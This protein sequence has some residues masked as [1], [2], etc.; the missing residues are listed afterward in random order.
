VKE[1]NRLLHPTAKHQAMAK[2]YADSELTVAEIATMFEVS[3]RV[4]Y[5]AASFYKI[6]RTTWSF[7]PS[8]S[9]LTST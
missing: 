6:R 1:K 5:R 3:E 4:V 9:A 8:R 7:Q 2:L